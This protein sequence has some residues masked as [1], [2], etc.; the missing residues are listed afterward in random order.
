MKT[1]MKNSL[2]SLLLNSNMLKT[3]F[4][5]SIPPIRTNPALYLVYNFFLS[6]V[7]F[8]LLRFSAKDI[9]FMAQSNKKERH[10]IYIFC[11]FILPP[12]FLR[13]LSLGSLPSVFR[14]SRPPFHLLNSLPLLYPLI[15]PPFFPSL[16]SPLLNSPLLR[17]L[18]PFPPVYESPPSLSSFPPSSAPLS[19]SSIALL[20]CFSSFLFPPP[21]PSSSVSSSP[22]P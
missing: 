9:F 20:S 11:L 18:P 16:S 1:P 13:L 17:L 15:F 8:R 3:L 5:I 14:L 12:P 6:S 7:S 21:S 2:G 22:T 19:P 4:P 10:F